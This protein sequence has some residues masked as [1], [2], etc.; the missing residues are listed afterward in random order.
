M[1]TAINQYNTAAGRQ[2][3]PSEDAEAEGVAQSER[4]RKK[5]NV[6][7]T[8][9][10]VDV[11]GSTPRN[12]PERIALLEVAVMLGHHQAAEMILRRLADSSLHTIG[13]L[14]TTCLARHLGAAAAFLGRPEEGHHHQR[15]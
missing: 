12:L 11:R 14:Y 3:R 8:S 1:G 10:I 2:P 4:L 5:E 6:K 7:V 15:G 9:Y 13:M